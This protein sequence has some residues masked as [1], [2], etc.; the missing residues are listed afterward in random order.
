[1]K[2]NIKSIFFFSI[3][4]II[5]DQVIKL[6]ISGKMMVNQST[7]LIRN[8]LTIT[9]THNTGAAF[10]ILNDSRILLIV[11]GIL[12]LGFI[13]LYIFKQAVIDDLDVFT[14]AL[15]IGGIAGN[16]IDRCIYGYV[17]DYLSFNFGS[18]YFPVFNLADIF[19]VISII[20]IVARTLKGDLWNSK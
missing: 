13:I 11:I 6:F 18:Y 12:A 9:L 20:F 4:F 3:I 17:I 2:E 16:L 15:L 8:F 5:L 1:M 14:Y 7:I 19:I 10:N